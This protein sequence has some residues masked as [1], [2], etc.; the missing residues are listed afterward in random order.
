MTID[1]GVLDALKKDLIIAAT[2]AGCDRSPTTYIVVVDRYG[3]RMSSPPTA[4]TISGEESKYFSLTLLKR[5]QEMS[6]RLFNTNKDHAL[7]MLQTDVGSLFDD[8]VMVFQDIEDAAAW[9]ALPQHKQLDAFVSYFV[10]DG[11]PIYGLS[12]AKDQA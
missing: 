7:Q 9:Y 6:A 5:L 10:A 12:I 4:R 1:T 11:F 2:L 3:E 8:R